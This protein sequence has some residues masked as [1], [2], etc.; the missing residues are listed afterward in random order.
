M[1]LTTDILN[2]HINPV[3]VETGTYH[4]EAVEMALKLGFKTIHTIEWDPD[5]ARAAKTRYAANPKVYTYQ[6]DSADQL[7]PI[8]KGLTQPTTFWLDAHPLV[9]PMPLFTPC[10]PLLREILVLKR[11]LPNIACTLLMD[12]M[13]TFSREE[14]AMLVFAMKQLWPTAQHSF[15]SDHL[16]TDD[17]YCCTIPKA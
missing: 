13:R 14:L 5:M 8:V 17:V 6:G 1:P 7:I 9:T 3:F 12:D 10:F 15:Y 16:A 2:K 4:C 11:F